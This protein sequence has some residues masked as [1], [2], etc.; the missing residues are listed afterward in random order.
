VK[1]VCHAVAEETRAPEA[2]LLDLVTFVQ[3][4][5]GHDQRYALDTAKIRRDCAWSPRETFETGL[6]KTVR[7]YLQ[8]PDWLTSV[9][10]GEYQRWIDLNYGTR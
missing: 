1:R 2:E 10:T 8:H 9:R 3:D 4:R 6:V 5:P 7:W